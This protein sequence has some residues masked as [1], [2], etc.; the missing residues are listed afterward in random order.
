MLPQHWLLMVVF[1][2]IGYALGQVWKAPA[3]YVG[4][5]S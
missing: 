3:Q 5:S 2:V 4:L 1:L